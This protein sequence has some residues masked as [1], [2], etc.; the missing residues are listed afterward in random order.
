MRALS[1]QPLWLTN[2]KPD[3]LKLGQD[4]RSSAC[5]C[6]HLWPKVL[7]GISGFAPLSKLREIV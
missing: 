6:V 7:I 2:N 4:L 1:A 3:A 5:I